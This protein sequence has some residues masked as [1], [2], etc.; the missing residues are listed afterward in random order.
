MEFSFTK[1]PT[2]F[3]LLLVESLCRRRTCV[4]GLSAC[5]R[6]CPLPAF[7]KPKCIPEER[8]KPVKPLRVCSFSTLPQLYTTGCFSFL[9]ELLLSSFL[10]PM[11]FCALSL[12]SPTVHSDLFL[13]F[14]CIFGSFFHSISLPTP[15]YL[16]FNQILN[17]FCGQQTNQSHC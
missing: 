3:H 17:S 8:F 16:P 6:C 15:G 2:K 12:L 1:V 14:L 7:K 4:M 9:W 10:S 11:S 13:V 5:C